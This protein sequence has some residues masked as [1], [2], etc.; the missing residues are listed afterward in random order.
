MD[1]RRMIGECAMKVTLPYLTVNRDRKGRPRYYVRKR[2]G[3]SILIKA[4]PGTPTFLERYHAALAELDGHKPSSKPTPKTWRWLC[5]LYMASPE[6]DSLSAATRAQRRNVLEAMWAEPRVPGAAELM[7]ECPLGPFTS[8]AVRMLRDRKRDHPEA[9]NH[10]IKCIRSVFAWAIEAQHVEGPNPAR[11]IANLR[12]KNPEGHHTWTVDEVRQYERRHQ[13]GTK[14]RLA[15]ALLLFTGVRRSDLV[16]LGRPMVRDGWLRFTV[17]KSRQ[18]IEIPIL[19]EL[20]AVLDATPLTGIG[21]WLVTQYG[22]PFTVA[23]FGNWFR[24]RCNEAGLTHCTAHGLRKAGATMAAENGAT[25]HQLQAIF[26]W[27]TL[28]QVERYTRKVRRRKLAG[29]AMGLIVAKEDG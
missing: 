6:W 10:R 11:D 28:K 27:E 21:T 22:K 23:G 4:K 7:G 19:P 1:L 20:Q 16:T 25:G 15:L 9:A 12:S 14:A 2:L 26:G 29:E 17:A 24:D 5:T 8:K 13:L 3:R 18:E